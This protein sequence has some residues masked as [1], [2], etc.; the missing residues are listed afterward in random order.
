MVYFLIYAT[1]NL[2][3]P[4]PSSCV[5]IHLEIVCDLCIPYGFFFLLH[6]ARAARKERK[7]EKYGSQMSY[8]SIV[9]AAMHLHICNNC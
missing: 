4:L 5:M 1:L 2:V 9:W 8:H 7:V 6:G 3:D